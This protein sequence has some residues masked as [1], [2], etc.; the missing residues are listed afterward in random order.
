MNMKLW[1]ALGLA[2]LAGVATTGAIIARNERARAQLTPDQ[3]R[4]RLQQRLQQSEAALTEAQ[5][6]T[7]SNA[8]A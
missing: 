4:E 8:R 5:E 7:D 2:G 1:K 6:S 3:V